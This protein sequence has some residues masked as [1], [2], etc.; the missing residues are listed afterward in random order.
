M[1]VRAAV[2]CL[3]ALSFACDVVIARAAT[4]V[5]VPADAATLTTAI[6]QVSN[7]GVI[8]ISSGT[9]TAPSGGFQ[10]SGLSKR[11]TV[12]AAPGAN[13]VLSGG[14]TKDILRLLNSPGSGR[15]VVFEGLTFAN[16][17]STTAGVSGG[18]TLANATATFVGCTFLQNVSNTSSNG[19][20]AI[21][22][23]S[24][25][26]VFLQ[27]SVFDGNT[28]KLAG[29]AI[30]AYEGS[31]V[32]IH[33][34]EF[35]DNHTN[36]SGHQPNAF[37]GAIAVVDAT[38]RVTQ[39][40]FEG[41]GAGFAGGAIYALG[42]WVDPVSTPTTDV[43]I[44]N[45]TFVD[46]VASPAVGVTPPGATEGGAIHAEDQTSV[47]VFH[48][49]FESNV[50]QTGGA[51]S[52]YRCIARIEH[53]I[54][55]GNVAGGTGAGQG[56]GGALFVHSDDVS[57]PSTN[58]GAINRRSADLSITDTLLAGDSNGAGNARMG[59]CVFA[60]GDTA[61]AYGSGVPAQGGVAGNRAP[62]TLDGVVLSDCDVLGDA[63]VPGYGGALAASLADVAMTDSL[64]MLSDARASAG[65]EGAGGALAL[66][67][68][69]TASVARSLF[70]A[71][72]ARTSGG[73]IRL[74]GGNLEL[75]SSALVENSITNSDSGAAIFLL[76]LAGSG[77]TAPRDVTGTISDCIFSNDTGPSAYTIM[78][79]D[80]T[81]GPINT[82]T[83]A[84][85]TFQPDTTFDYFHS[86][87]GGKNAAG[88]NALVVNRANAT[89]TV[90]APSHDNVGLGTAPTVG[91]IWAVPSQQLPAGA[92]GDT[93]GAAESDLAYAWSG[94]A[95]ATLDGQVRSGNTGLDVGPSTGL[96]TLV[97]NGS[98]F[99]DTVGQAAPP[100]T[101]LTANPYVITSGATSSLGW[102][103][104]A[105]TFVDEVIDQ[106]VSLASPAS[107]GSV[108]V[109]PAVTTVWRGFLIAE[110]GGA[111]G[112]GFVMLRSGT[113][114]FD[115]GFESG[116]LGGW[117]DS[118][119]G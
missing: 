20:G 89:T 50:A 14:G 10:I 93:A 24:A 109:Q 30:L 72:S 74:T 110:E 65:A 53:S 71:N 98:P 36:V 25:S 37:G 12:R 80:Y 46:D 22:A 42:S 111:V 75:T 100:Q 83:Y 58:F 39:S 117:S 27:D 106:G 66:F 119:G 7:G 59:G 18:V 47:R 3:I 55:R 15:P 118:Q 70:V 76:P 104:I 108:S 56:I 45:S 94:A 63:G 84:A 91:G 73:V 57:D 43:L 61:R 31:R 34:T 67:S 17:R 48:S 8:E 41:N 21:L 79:G 33:A 4:F 95:Q 6:S 52:C 113:P 13:V 86:L 9:Y 60:G 82:V 44:T 88:L 26:T 40:R 5:R 102:A 38:L 29:G 85:N 103:T 107:A 87:V 62:V 32:M 90:K 19:G 96:H 99:T 51:L 23:G 54:L 112:Q 78:D 116:G 81:N 1:R 2:A 11:F 92:S 97:V 16:G 115:G 68:D 105:G 49:R 114:I 64:V 101:T 35:V 77:A 28:A 69:T